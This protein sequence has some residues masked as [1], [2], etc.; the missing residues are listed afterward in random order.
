[1]S[2]QAEVSVFKCYGPFRR[3]R[4]R[5]SLIE[6]LGSLEVGGLS[7]YI[8]G[9][10]Y[11]LLFCF[12]N[13]VAS[14]LPAPYFT[15]CNSSLQEPRTLSLVVCFC[16][17]ILDQQQ[18]RKQSTPT[19]RKRLL[20]RVLKN[21]GWRMKGVLSDKGDHWWLLWGGGIAADENHPGKA[22]V[23]HSWGRRVS[24]GTH[25]VFRGKEEVSKWD[26]QEPGT[27]KQYLTHLCSCY[28]VSID[29]TL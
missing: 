14:Q 18:E 9:P 16:Q 5:W 7:G 22:E 26:K 24:V 4:K 10:H 1:M 15:P 12:L 17:D 25:C 23:Q 3:W 28:S 20:V 21:R 8:A 19:F 29:R 2:P 11:L 27:W 13:E 6:G